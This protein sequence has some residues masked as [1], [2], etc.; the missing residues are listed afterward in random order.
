[1]ITIRRRLH[2]N[3]QM[4]LN[5][6]SST[7]WKLSCS[8]TFSAASMRG[9]LWVYSKEASMYIHSNMNT[10]YYDYTFI[11]SFRM[12]KLS[13]SQ[14]SSSFVYYVS[15]HY[16]SSTLASHPVG[17]GTHSTPTTSREAS[18]T[19]LRI[20]HSS[21]WNPPF[22]KERALPLHLAQP[23]PALLSDLYLRSRYNE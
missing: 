21:T 1:M 14:T 17:I 6:G 16:R 20:M 11:G 12:L 3:N 4:P 5:Q 15:W 2:R 23:K 18:K 22:S 8:S 13:F 10:K 9:E 19:F 7:F